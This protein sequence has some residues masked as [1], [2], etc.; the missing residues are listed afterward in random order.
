MPNKSSASYC[1][2]HSESKTSDFVKA[3][4]DLNQK[5]LKQGLY[6]RSDSVLQERM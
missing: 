1:L 3:K 5:I 6:L 2:R 4:E